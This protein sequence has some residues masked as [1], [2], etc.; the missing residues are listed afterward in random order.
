MKKLSCIKNIKSLIARKIKLLVLFTIT[1]HLLVIGCNNSDESSPMKTNGQDTLHSLNSNSISGRVDDDPVPGAVVSLIINDQT[2]IGSAT[3]NQ[4]GDYSIEIPEKLVSKIINSNCMTIIAKKN[5]KI[6]R[7]K[8]P[9]YVGGIYSGEETVIS[10]YTEAA[11]QISNEI[12]VN[13]TN[14]FIDFLTVYRNGEM[15]IKEDLKTYDLCYTVAQSIRTDF[16]DSNKDSVV[17][18]FSK[19]HSLKKGIEKKQGF[20]DY[21]EEGNNSYNDTLLDPKI[22]SKKLDNRSPSTI[23]ELIQ[24]IDYMIIN[25]PTKHQKLKARISNEFLLS[26]F[27]NEKQRLD[28]VKDGAIDMLNKLNFYYKFL[29]VIIKI[30]ESDWLLGSVIEISEDAIYDILKKYHDVYLYDK[31]NEE[32][33]IT[34]VQLIRESLKTGIPIAILGTTALYSATLGSIANTYFTVCNEIVLYKYIKTLGS[35]IIAHDYL[36]LYYKAGESENQL[37]EYLEVENKEEAIR[38]IADQNK[39]EKPEYGEGWDSIF[40]NIKSFLSN[41]DEYDVKHVYNI[42]DSLNV[43][44]EESFQ[45]SLKSRIKPQ[46]TILKL[47]TYADEELQEP[48]TL[49]DGNSYIFKLESEDLCL[50]CDIFY[51][52]KTNGLIPDDP[53]LNSMKYDYH[54]PSTVGVEINQNT[55][56]KAVA[57]NKESGIFSDCMMYDLKFYKQVTVPTNLQIIAGDGNVNLSWNNVN[58]ASYFNVYQ[59]DGMFY[60]LIKTTKQTIVRI[61][62]LT[63]E[64]YYCFAVKALNSAFTSNFSEE[65][66]ATPKRPVIIPKNPTIIKIE[67]TSGQNTISWNSV[68]DAEK[69]VVYW[70]TTGNVSIYDNSKIIEE[71]T[72]FAHKNLMNGITY[73]Y[74]VIAVNSYGE[75]DISNEVYGTPKSIL[76]DLIGTWNGEAHSSTGKCIWDVYIKFTSLDGYNLY[77]SYYL[78][79]KHGGCVGD[80][81]E[82]ELLTI[83]DKNVIIGNVNSGLI[84]GVLSALTLSGSFQIGDKWYQLLVEYGQNPN[85]YH[86]TFSVTKDDSNSFLSEKLAV[87]RNDLIIPK[88]AISPEGNY[89]LVGNDRQNSITFAESTGNIL[90]EYE[91][92]HDCEMESSAISKNG[93]II[94]VG[95][96]SSYIFVFSKD[97][98]LLWKKNVKGEISVDI[99]DAGDKIF[100]A[101]INKLLCYNRYGNLIWSKDIDTRRWAIWQISV[102]INGETILLKTNSDII[103]CNN[104]GNETHFFDIAPGNSLSGASLDLYGNKFIVCYKSSTSDHYISLY[105]LS[106]GLLWNKKVNNHGEVSIDI[107]DNFFISIRNDGDYILN[108]NGDVVA[109]STNGGI[110]HA[111]SN[112]GK[113]VIIGYSQGANVF[114]FNY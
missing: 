12:D 13:Q 40:D 46:K 52:L 110:N 70:N 65:K 4:N 54:Q 41:H 71:G 31:Y 33:L 36:N 7:S 29:N 1:T 10:H 87:F 88:V 114:K 44:I 20:E 18:G 37:F 50:E 25:N 53:D 60:D 11:V 102:S 100:A 61:D 49:I 98:D 14:F 108:K 32:V 45:L 8:I 51:N 16:Y 23:D 38:K 82:N 84:S 27:L 96:Q 94:V 68:K 78:T 92:P 9:Y 101:A 79:N 75:S 48:Y 30:I 72:S 67:T 15:I 83:E 90:W 81:S 85:D 34:S 93:E 24:H 62:N 80:S 47:F 76:S 104:N 6:L 91:L 22:L 57:I 56:I 73:Y 99:T 64:R 113:I 69:Y 42:I 77:A 111:I 28:E 39:L 35:N 105:S 86:G 21:I 103:I 112:N 95:G 74:I 66:C 17:L 107:F 58:G 59:K 26:Y 43:L 63:N 89:I 2:I 109:S 55:I 97:G 3:T 106:D 5:G 19:I